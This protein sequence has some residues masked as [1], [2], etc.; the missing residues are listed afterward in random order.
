M[1]CPNCSEVNVKKIYRNK[2]MPYGIFLKDR[3]IDLE[4]SICKNCGFVF[5]NSA[6]CNE[7]DERIKKLYGLYEIDKQY[8]FPKRDNYALKSLE[9]LDE[10]IENRIDYNI[11]EIGSNRGDFLYLLKEKF[12][13]INVLGCEPTKFKNLKVLTIQSFFNAELFSMK[14]DLIIL[15]HTLEHIKYPKKFLKEV[16][17]VLKDNGKLYIEV[18]NLLNSL[19]KRIEDFTPDHVN[20]FYLKTLV[21]TVPDLKLEKFYDEPFL[22]AIFSKNGSFKFKEGDIV[23]IESKF[24]AFQKSIDDIASKLD[25]YERVIFYGVGNYYLWVYYRFK[26]ILEQKELYFMDD[27][28]EEDTIL[29]LHKIKDYNSN[30]LIILCSSNRKIQ[31]KMAK[32]LSNV[33][34]LKPY[35]GIFNV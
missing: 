21:S 25:K 30:D 33:N 18:P 7:Y 6:F 8:D 24:I 29:N 1:N 13:K 28:V 23:D 31:E 26:N 16:I 14:F 19:D 32:K 20:Y 4:I 10:F 12:S 5:Q 27:F 35:S 22:Y 2:N 17:K 9:F 3:Y 34:I 11:L 15:R